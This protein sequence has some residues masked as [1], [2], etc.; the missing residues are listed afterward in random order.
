MSINLFLGLVLAVFN[1]SPDKHSTYSISSEDWRLQKEEEIVFEKESELST[2]KFS[3]FDWM[4]VEVPSSILSSFV[5][6]G[7]VSEPIRDADIYSIP[8]LYMQGCFWYRKRFILPASL[9]KER[10]FLSFDGI[11]SGAQIWLNSKYVGVVEEHR[12]SA[13]FDVTGLVGG[14]NALAVKINGGGDESCGIWGDVYFH[15]TGD[16]SLDEPVV[17][18]R[19]DEEG[20]L[21]KLKLGALV[22]NRSRSRK[23]VRLKGSFAGQPFELSSHLGAGESKVL[24]AFIDVEDEAL[25]WPG[26]Y[27]PRPLYDLHLSLMVGRNESD[28]LSTKVA[29]RQVEQKGDSLLVNG[30]R[31][32]PRG[33]YMPRPEFL[34]RYNSAH[35]EILAAYL[36]Q[37][38]FNVLLCPQ[39]VAPALSEAADRHGILILKELEAVKIDSPIV[40]NYESL[41]LYIDPQW[42][43]PQGDL[44]RIHGFDLKT[45]QAKAFSD[46]LTALFGAPQDAAAFC[47]LGQWQNYSSVRSLLECS[48]CDSTYTPLL[49]SHPYY[50]SMQA[51]T[52]DYFFDPTSAFY[53]AKKAL[54]PIHVQY[55]EKDSSLRLL[56]RTTRAESKLKLGIQWFD[57]KGNSL[58]DEIVDIARLN[59]LETLC[60]GTFPQPAPEACFMKLGLYKGEELVCENTYFKPQ[61]SLKAYRNLPKAVIELG[62]EVRCQ[63]GMWVMDYKL[64][65]LGEVPALMLHAQLRDEQ[66]QR[67]L[68][69]FW[70]DNYI[71]L[72]PGES[73]KLQAEVYVS[74]CP[75]MPQISLEGLNL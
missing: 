14:K 26:T 69:V 39:D 71:H 49:F 27:G 55:D 7:E 17:E 30:L 40:P 51:C 74:T 60:L 61:G 22:S 2:V 25:W 8:D 18:L 28:K 54:E 43:W 59:A 19:F 5:K 48:A 67:I 16:A 36:E 13:R 35:Y 44:W 4:K 3:D 6:S 65:N 56:N 72:L 38:N 66:G 47:F 41:A 42:D 23:E 34:M 10:I 70:S 21:S 11:S 64:T 63:N 37:Q 68:P 62:G 52:Y 75:K 33:V 32:V 50:S 31:I 9:V 46:S 24:S 58:K 1:L 12:N 57:F 15:S 73:V 53:A 29:L 45:P 20:K